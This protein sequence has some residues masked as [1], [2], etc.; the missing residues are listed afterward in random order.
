VQGT[1]FD[2]RRSSSNSAGAV[3]VAGRLS[4][5]GSAK[6]PSRW[7]SRKLLATLIVVAV[8]AGLGGA[9][10]LAYV[11]LKG[12]AAQLQAD[13]TVYLQAGQRELEAGKASLTQANTKH[14]VS[15]V[16]EAAAH[17][18]AARGQFVAAGQL[19]DSSRLLQDLEKVP[20]VRDVVLSRHAA[21]DGIAEMGT[22]ISDAGEELSILDLQLI[23]PA[24]SGPAGHTM[25]T[26]LDQV[27]TSLI[28]VR[29]DFG[30]AKD[31]ASRVDVHVLPGGQQATF[32][33]ARGTVDLAVTGLD[34][35]ERLVP[36][37]HEVLGGN[38]IR[39]YLVEQLDPAELRAGGGFIGT[40]S[41]VRAYHGTLTVIKSGNAYELADPRPLPGHAGFIPQLGP[42][43]EVIPQ[44]SWSFVDSNIYPDFASNAKRAEAFVQPRLGSKVKIDGVISMD[45]YV[46]AKL[47]ELTGPLTVPGFGIKVDANNI[48]PLLISGA[49]KADAAHKAIPSALA[50]VLLKRVAAFPSDRWPA[51]ISAFNGLAAARHLQTFFNSDIAQSEITRIGWSGSVNPT[52][53]DDYMMEIESNYF[54][55]KANY[56]LTRHYTVVLTRHG[57]TLHH[58][59]TVDLT[60]AMPRGLTERTAYRV[61][62]R[63]YIGHGTSSAT[64][65]LRPVKYSNPAPPSGTA[66]M[67]GWLPDIAGSGG[68]G[69]A[70]FEYDSP[71][72]LRDK[73]FQQIYWQKQPGT[74]NDTIDL[75]WNDGSGHAFMIS[76]A[77]GQDLVIMLSP[78][79]IGMTPGKPAQATLPS[80]SLG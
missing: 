40:Y 21:V 54:G 41:L 2:G 50:G 62:V 15:L 72:P 9:A 68:R 67:D 13:L 14:D 63:L 65:N 25:L 53:A 11:S 5:V 46:V 23:K 24:S 6:Q 77:L 22:A 20:G 7:R 66:L 78:T 39:T 64:N 4:R 36:V 70:I 17:F 61:N 47:L 49:I 59:V 26:T 80:L 37:L 12:R 79:G 8:V 52:G 33:K 32:V 31:A 74:G 38:G 51:V 10:D 19:A 55:D 56:F 76:G 34:E 3:E 75:T 43:R 27:H 48:I 57:A 30:R 58:K 71:W 60:N 73:G 35:F 44:V 1:A 28:K 16:A 29:A 69:R 18:V 42:Y 45:Y